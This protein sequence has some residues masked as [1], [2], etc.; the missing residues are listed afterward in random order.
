MSIY[1]YI[2]AIPSFSSI[3]GAKPTQKQLLTLV[4]KVSLI[5]WLC[6]LS[7]IQSI[8]A[9]DK[10]QDVENQSAIFNG[11]FS[12]R[13]KK[14]IDNFYK[15]R[16]SERSLICYERQISTLQQFTILHAPDEGTVSLDNERG[17][18]ILGLAILITLDL[19]DKDLSNGT[20]DKTIIPG[21]IQQQIRMIETPYY[22]YF[23]RAM[24][25]Y[26]LNSDDQDSIIKKYISL[27]QETVNVDP[28]DYILGGL[29]IASQEI[30]R[31][32]EDQASE[33][34][35]V[36][37]SD[38]IE[39]PI[40]KKIIYAYEKIRCATVDVM[41]E[42]MLSIEKNRSIRD[43]NLITLSRFPIIRFLNEGA[44][45]LNLTSLG[46]SLFDGIRH[47]IL[48]SE[49]EKERSSVKNIIK[50]LG[51]MYG[52]VFEKYVLKLLEEVFADRFIK[53]PE[54]KYPGNAD[55]LVLFSDKVLVIEIKSNHFAAIQHYKQ[56]I[57][58]EYQS[59]ISA[60]GFKKGISQL[61]STIRKL[62]GYKLGLP[63]LPYYDWTIKPIIPIIVSEEHVPLFPLVWTQLYNDLEETISDLQ[64]GSGK[65]GRLRFLSIDDVEIIPNLEINIDL[66]TL[67][68]AW[69]NDIEKSEFTFRNYLH[70]S[71]YHFSDKFMF[72]KCKD[73]CRTLESRLGFDPDNL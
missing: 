69:G 29:L 43:W 26:E 24:M 58:E 49:L 32:N 67:L 10:F 35:G 36:L 71:G 18:H 70:S 56:K 23:A 40:Q 16:P 31:T 19:M 1:P 8:I 73:S 9:G 25:L 13:L 50:R 6:F 48:T 41:R 60:A 65:L 11:V 44:Y 5:D 53:I 61:K 3:F 51:G 47:T 46:R 4:K 62:W 28:L 30:I 42:S 22:V 21:I 64:D 14:L 15:N 55:C 59:E 52:Q 72:D 37:L 66:A 33:W 39:N 54:D 68:L 20:D 38:Q 34:K 17:R 12:S 2:V 57:I 45:I 27:F 63:Q 7:R